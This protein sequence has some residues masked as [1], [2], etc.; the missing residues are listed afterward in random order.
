MCIII[1]HLLTIRN[2]IDSSIKFSVHFPSSAFIIRVM[3]IAG[4]DI[5]HIDMD[6]FYASVE[7]RDNPAL[8]GKPVIVGARPEERGVV[9][10]A[11]YEIRK[12]GVHSAMS[13]AR[14][15]RL[16][17]Q[18]VVLPVRMERYVEIS[19]QIRVIFAQFTPIIEPLALDEA[20]LDVT[21]YLNLFGSAET[22][23]REIKQQIRE[24]HNL[25]VSAGVAPN[26]FLAKLA[27]DLGK[28]DGL[29]VITEETKQ[30]ILDPLPISRIGGIGPVTEKALQRQGIHVIEQ[31]RKASKEHLQSILGNQAENLYKLARGIDDS[32]V[33]PARKTKSISAEETFAVD[34]ADLTALS[35]ILLRQVEEVAQRLRDEKLEARTVTLKLRRGD[36]QIITRSHTLDSSTNITELIW[37][38]AKRLLEQWYKSWGSP[39]RLLGVGVSNL[40]KEGQG[41]Q[42]LFTDES[43]VKHKKVDDVMDKVRQKYGGNI[44]KR[45]L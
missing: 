37:R 23:A 38:E 45:G 14:A 36:F 28:P 8:K 7:Q 4:R 41:Q 6:A 9:A 2:R 26:K 5:I 40:Q 3:T 44:L 12:Y 11:S 35:Q 24:K 39:L 10:A 29:M 19:R 43:E 33:E 17:P 13:T 21:D 34:T 16:C 20:Y 25:P 1:I 32:P 22:I 15:L 30:R 31:L 42:L 27:C 18:G